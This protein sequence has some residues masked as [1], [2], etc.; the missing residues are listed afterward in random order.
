VALDETSVAVDLG[1]G[2]EGGPSIP[3]LGAAISGNPTAHWDSSW[4]VGLRGDLNVFKWRAAD[5]N[6]TLNPRDGL[7]GTLHLTIAGVLDGNGRLHVWD[8]GRAHFTGHAEVSTQITQGAIDHRCKFGFC[9]DI[10]PDTINGPQAAVDFGEFRTPDKASDYGLKGQVHYLTYDPAF[11]VDVYGKARFD[12]GGL[13]QYRLVDQAAA[14][15]GSARAQG[16]ADDTYSVAVDATPTLIVAMGRDTGNLTLTLT[17]PTGRVITPSSGDAAIGYTATATQSLYTIA[18]PVTGNWTI[19][20][21][22]RTGA[23]NYLLDV[24]GAPVVPTIQQAPTMT[25]AANGY[26]VSFAGTGVPGSTY[27]GVSDGSCHQPQS[28]VALVRAC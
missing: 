6:L 28:S 19:T 1:I 13:K 20:V 17:D 24:L 5:G 27:S 8:D 4:A 12:L 3:N 2:V 25:P 7:V 14:A 23:E 18:N 16:L 11:F 15:S 21:G 26:T 10:P 9:L 22:N